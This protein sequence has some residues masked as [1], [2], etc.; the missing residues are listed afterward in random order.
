MEAVLASE[1]MSSRLE[2]AFAAAR[3][4]MV[5]ALSVLDRF[6]CGSFDSS[7]LDSGRS[8]MEGFVSNLSKLS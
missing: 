3:E 6:A 4:R 2:Y 8:R 5:L 7:R 1:M